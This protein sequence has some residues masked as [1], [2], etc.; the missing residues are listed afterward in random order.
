MV[1]QLCLQQQILAR[2]QEI[3]NI[4]LWTSNCDTITNT[5]WAQHIKDF[6]VSTM[7]LQQRDDD[8][9]VLIL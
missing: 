5:Q 8:F 6:G 4:V 3:T 9:N 1:H 7:L 2:Q